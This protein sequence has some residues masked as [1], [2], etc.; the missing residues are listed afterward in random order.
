MKIYYETRCVA[1]LLPTE[2]GA[3][4]RYDPEWLATKQAF[5]ISLRMPLP[6]MR[7][8]RDTDH[9]FTPD[10]VTPW[11]ANLLP[12]GDALDAI[13]RLMGTSQ[14]DIL[15]ILSRIGRDTSG[16]LSF[17]E[18]GRTRMSYRLIEREDDLERMINELPARPLM[19]GE[20]GVSISLAGVQ[21][22]MGVFL[23]EDDRIC[24]PTNG[25]P[26]NWILKPDSKLLWG[27][28]W[29][30][31]FCMRLAAHAGLDVPQVR[32]GR[33]GD[34]EYLLV[35]RY[36]RLSSKDGKIWRRL[37]Q[38]DFAQAAGIFPQSKYERNQTGR[39]GLKLTDMVDLTRRA[40]RQDIRKFISYV[41][42][43]TIACNPDAHAKNYS[44]LISASGAKLSPIYDVMCGLV[45]S[46]INK[47]LVNSINGKTDGNYLKARHWQ[48][49][50]RACGLSPRILLS[51]VAELCDRVGSKLDATVED[52]VAL[53]PASRPMAEDCRKYIA[54][55]ILYLKNGLRETE[56]RTS[57][58]SDE[59]GEGSTPPSTGF[60]T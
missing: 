37:H 57:S 17:Q 12:E 21:S 27:S 23:D 33:A 4:L 28:V 43:N 30:E 1:E 38:E 45:W 35:K 34:R 60:P 36:D 40:A 53:D 55:R 49:E 3:R 51:D 8:G 10:I 9:E 6:K 22:K 25:S 24:I 7:A 44:F 59:E 26:S 46:G 13:S 42:F 14:S 31:A 5:A 18:A 52:L 11:I 19:A 48:R 15:G 32:V 47:N 39:P 50:A 20:E 16:A 54:Q 29:N 41:I 2:Q 58:S 56:E